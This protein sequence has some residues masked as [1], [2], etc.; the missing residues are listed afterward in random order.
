MNKSASKCRSHAALHY[1]RLNA[2]VL[3][4]IYAPNLN[5]VHDKVL[6]PLTTLLQLLEVPAKLVLKR[7]DKLLDY[8]C[9]RAHLERSR[10]KEAKHARDHLSEC[11]K[12]YEALNNQLLEDLPPLIDRCALVF[13]HCFQLY[14]LALTNIHAQVRAQLTP[15]ITHVSCLHPHSTN[16]NTLAN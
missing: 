3:N 15:L 10:E 11:Q 1:V 5:F 7:R 4:H 13:A 14:L 2:T 12:N 9:A 6:A 16:S 8:E